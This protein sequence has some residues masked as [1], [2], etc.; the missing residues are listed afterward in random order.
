MYIPNV[1]VAF[2][3]RLLIICKKIESDKKLENY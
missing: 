2:I 1:V 3:L